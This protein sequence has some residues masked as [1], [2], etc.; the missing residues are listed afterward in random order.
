MVMFQKFGLEA[1][2]IFKHFN[3][4]N[5]N[6]PPHLHRAFELI[7][8]LHGQL[9]ISIESRQYMVNRGQFVIVFPNQIH[10]FNMAPQTEIKIILFAPELIPA[11]IEQYRECVPDNPVFIYHQL[12]SLNLENRFAI[13]GFLY[14]VCGRLIEQTSLTRQPASQNA[15]VVHQLVRFVSDHYQQ[16]CSLK[17]AAKQIG[18]DYAYLSRIFKATMKMSFTTYLN[19]YR[20][21]Q[22]EELLKNTTRKI[23]SISFQVGYTNLRTFNR[24]FQKIVNVQPTTYRQSSDGQTYRKAFQENYISG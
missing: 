5:L 19:H 12:G 13:K 21:S 16:E 24:N 18:Y 11:F 23:T 22:A 2:P 8:V 3:L 1:T 7:T 4:T 20:I 15:D 14:S 9:R 10:G 17:Q 6:Y